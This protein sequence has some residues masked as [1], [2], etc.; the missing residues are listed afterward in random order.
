MPEVPK[1]AGK[2]DKL[3]SGTR[4]MRPGNKGDET[5]EHVLAKHTSKIHWALERSL[6]LIGPDCLTRLGSGW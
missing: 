2:T 3:S 5:W 1:V 4:E 6:S